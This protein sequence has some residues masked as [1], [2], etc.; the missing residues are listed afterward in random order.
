MY[1]I[2]IENKYLIDLNTENVTLIG[3]LRN[4]EYRNSSIIFYTEW[5][6]YFPQL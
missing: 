5:Q 4:L 6:F 3:V 1:H 2:F